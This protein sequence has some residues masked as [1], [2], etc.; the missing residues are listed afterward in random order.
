MKK[1]TNLVFEGRGIKCLALVGSLL[2]LDNR[3]LLPGVT[4]IAGVSGGSI[5][6]FM[7]SCGLSLSE[8][9]RLSYET[10]FE[11]LIDD[12]PGLFKD[13]FRFVTNF[14]WFKG[15]LFVNW[16]EDILASTT[17]NENITFKDL[18]K[19]SNKN[20]KYKDLYIIGTNLSL[21]K[22]ETYS[23]ET[24]PDMKIKDALRISIGFPFLFQVIRNK[25]NDI[26]I[27]GGMAR[28]YPVDIFDDQ[29]Y[30]ENKINTTFIKPFNEETLGFK[31]VDQDISEF[32]R[33][34]RMPIRGLKSFAMSIITFMQEAASK[35]YI[36]DKDWLRTVAV[37]TTGVDV[38]EF[39]LTNDKVDLL[40]N[41]GKKSVAQFFDNESLPSIEM[42]LGNNL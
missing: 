23:F 24:T 25:N 35:M 31:L 2:E 8:I 27:D 6:A 19:L 37:D 7:L 21:M 33:S 18:H 17:G 36:N 13:I 3:D 9:E 39:K 34:K 4:R 12:D 28:T 10:R 29:K 11:T 30:S 1:I 5:I 26:L 40:I 22:A 16:V 14:G 42:S 38:M 32:L 15:D 20:K 41:N